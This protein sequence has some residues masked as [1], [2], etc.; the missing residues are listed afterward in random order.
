[1]S[2]DSQ[3]GGEAWVGIGRRVRRQGHLGQDRAGRGGA[4]GEGV[5]RGRG[6]ERAGDRDSAKR[7]ER[8]A[9]DDRRDPLDV[10]AV[11]NDEWRRRAVG[12]P[13]TRGPPVTLISSTRAAAGP[14]GRPGVAPRSGPW[15]RHERRSL[16]RSTR[17]PVPRGHEGR[18]R[19]R[20]R[21][22]ACTTRTRSCS[23]NPNR[24]TGR[25]R[26]GELRSTRSPRAAT[27]WSSRTRAARPPPRR[28]TT[29]RRV[30]ADRRRRSARS[31]PEWRPPA[32]PTRPAVPPPVWPRPAGWRARP[33]PATP[34][35][36]LPCPPPRAQP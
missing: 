3:R 5:D 35:S 17:P 12:E 21:L 33:G 24:P 1:M 25:R 9:V 13:V 4:E 6:N 18:A 32:A 11:G 8:Q 29:L 26:A 23:S 31:E 20:R 36:Q 15:H 14:A 34:R 27:R 19:A 22:E 2:A 28:R 16:H 10:P 30:P 7:D